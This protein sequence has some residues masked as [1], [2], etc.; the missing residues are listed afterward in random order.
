MSRCVL[1]RNLVNE[2]ALVLWGLLRQIENKRLKNITCASET[3]A[4]RQ[5]TF[6][7]CVV[8]EFAKEKILQVLCRKFLP[9]L[10]MH[11]RRKLL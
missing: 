6:R 7:G 3:L 10:K 2:E 5:S 11:F 1:S 9:L 4:V 8:T